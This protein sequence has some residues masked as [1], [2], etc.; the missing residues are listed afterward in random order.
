MENVYLA[1]PVMNERLAQLAP[2]TMPS[3]H[4]III[5][6]VHAL[7]FLY[8]VSRRMSKAKPGDKLG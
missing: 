4:F 2:I 1:E 5:A 7:I 3:K 6:Y 8:V